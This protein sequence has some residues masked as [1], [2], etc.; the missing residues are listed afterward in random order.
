M[1]RRA[2]RTEKNDWISVSRG[3]N[4]GLDFDSAGE[5]WLGLE[6]IRSVSKQGP[7]QLQVV[8]SDG[9][10]Q[11]LPV[12]RYP[13]RLDG[14]E[15]KF[16]L[17]L[18]DEASSPQMSTGSSGIPFSTADRDNDL[19]EDLSCAKMLSGTTLCSVNCVTVNGRWD[20]NVSSLPCFCCRRLV[21]Q[22]LR[23]LEPQRQI[24]QKA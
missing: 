16:A 4:E 14:E 5:F 17:H 7:Y 13:F 12:A 9:A 21:V 6:K 2:H 3:Q 18:E 1:V 23:R 24:S 22:Q 20:T 19:S 8:L 11:R 10:G 15:K